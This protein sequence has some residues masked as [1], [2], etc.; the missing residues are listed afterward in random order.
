MAL[1]KV[2]ETT[3]YGLVVPRVGAVAANAASVSANERSVAHPT[4][5]KRLTCLKFM[6]ALPFFRIADRGNP[7]GGRHLTAAVAFPC[8]NS[9]FSKITLPFDG[10]KPYFLPRCGT[11][12]R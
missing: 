3:P 4:L 7:I 6:S 12:T 5:A 9:A 11:Q 10:G 8:T 2:L 1:V